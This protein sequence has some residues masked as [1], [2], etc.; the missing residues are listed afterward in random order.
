MNTPEITGF[1]SPH[2]LRSQ[3][4]LS[5]PV[6]PELEVLSSASTVS[7][8]LGPLAVFVFILGHCWLSFILAY[9]PSFPMPKLFR[10][11]WALSL[12]QPVSLRP[13]FAFTPSS[14]AFNSLWRLF[15]LLYL[16]GRSLLAA[17][18]AGRPS[19]M[20]MPNAHRSRTGHTTWGCGVIMPSPMTPSSDEHQH[21]PATQTWFSG[22]GGSHQTDN[23]SSWISH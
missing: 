9:S 5:R 20:R 11:S 12:A 2:P 16:V 7:S 19:Q 17:D 6:S 15:W 22:F 1:Q 21:A 23:N 4:M 8:T 14:V 18:H 13:G 10:L 3:K